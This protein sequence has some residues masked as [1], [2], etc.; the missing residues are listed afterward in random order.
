MLAFGFFQIREGSFCLAKKFDTEWA[1]EPFE[2]DMTF[3]AR[4]MFGCRSAYL[5]GK[6]VMCLAENDSDPNWQ[7]ILLPTEREHHESLIREFPQLSPHKVLA[8]WLYL[9]SSDEDFEQ[10]AMSIGEKISQNDLRFGSVPKP[11]KKKKTGAKS[12]R[13]ERK[14]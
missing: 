9:P 2:D 4:H 10:V 3:E 1:F 13:K 11:R 12:P 5:R 6:I 14:K 8:K 7:G